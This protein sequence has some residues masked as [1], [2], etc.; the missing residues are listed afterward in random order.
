MVRLGWES[1]RCHL[2]SSSLQCMYETKT[3]GGKGGRMKTHICLL[4]HRADINFLCLV[5]LIGFATMYTTT[6]DVHVHRCPKARLWL[7]LYVVIAHLK[8]QTT[9]K[10]PNQLINRLHINRNSSFFK[11]CYYILFCSTFIPISSLKLLAC[12]QEGARTFHNRTLINL[13]K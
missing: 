8:L 4:F 1:V 7:R 10:F 3:Q 9:D 13:Q 12:V 2:S 6:T 11:P 5:V